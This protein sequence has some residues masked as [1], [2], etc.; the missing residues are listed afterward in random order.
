MDTLQSK[1]S[2]TKT[3]QRGLMAHGIRIGY[4][5]KRLQNEQETGSTKYKNIS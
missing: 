3:N 4:H 5:M 1:A 2:G